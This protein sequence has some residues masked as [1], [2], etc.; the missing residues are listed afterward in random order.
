MI[1]SRTVSK[2]KV[3]VQHKKNKDLTKSSLLLIYKN[4]CTITSTTFSQMTPFLF[5]S[6]YLPKVNHLFFSTAGRSYFQIFWT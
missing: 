2:I 4:F 6:S 5:E 1:F 3:E